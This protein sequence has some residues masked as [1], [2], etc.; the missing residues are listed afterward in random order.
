[1]ESTVPAASYASAS[2]R[3]RATTIAFAVLIGLDLVAVVSDYAQI[4]LLQGIKDGLPFTHAETTANDLRVG[5]IAFLHFAALLT[6]SIIFLTWI[7]RAHKNLVAL[8]V[9]NLRCSPRW[10]VGYYFIPYFSFFRPFQVMKEI[11]KAS[12]PLTTVDSWK[13]SPSSPLVTGWW[14]LYLAMVLH[15]YATWNASTRAALAHGSEKLGL[16]ISTSWSQ[17]H[18]HVMLIPAAFFAILVVRGVQ[19]RQDEKVKLVS[20]ASESEA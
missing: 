14:A 6:A 9:N 4:S 8:G 7:Y 15:G 13:K 19:A 10:A 16:L 17:L 20:A 2:G 11:W 18:G 5:I 1:M 3:A 12:G